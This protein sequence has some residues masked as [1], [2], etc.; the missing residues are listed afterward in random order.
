MLRATD[1][2]MP[3][4]LSALL[5]ALG[6]DAGH[7]LCRGRATA[8]YRQV[9]TQLTSNSRDCGQGHLLAGC[10][11]LL[12]WHLSF[13]CGTLGPHPDYYPHHLHYPILILLALSSSQPNHTSNHSS[14]HITL[15]VLYSPTP[16]GLPICCPDFPQTVWCQCSH[17]L[18]KL[19]QNHLVPVS[20]IVSMLC[21][22]VR[23]FSLLCSSSLLT[24]ATLACLLTVDKWPPDP[25]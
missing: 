17:L 19:P 9:W 23:L 25:Q 16:R 11:F 20:D 13:G 7:S 8:A 24:L 15:G 14:S 12:S 2:S 3:R 1:I 6:L 21:V 22:Q 10:H 18:P 5:Q 4:A